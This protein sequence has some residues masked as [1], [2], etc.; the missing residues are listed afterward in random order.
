[1]I[2]RQFKNKIRN[3]KISQTSVKK[4]LTKIDVE[5]ISYHFENKLLGIIEKNSLKNKK[6]RKLIKIRIK[7]G[8][9]NLLK[10]KK[11]I[12]KN[13]KKKKFFNS[14]HEI[15]KSLGSKNIKFSQGIKQKEFSLHTSKASNINSK[16]H[17]TSNSSQSTFN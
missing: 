11:N 13:S 3:W 1:M 2:S 17:Q 9:N 4:K 6:K 10:M 7:K 14:Q 5:N 8:E 15:K 12:F 16:N